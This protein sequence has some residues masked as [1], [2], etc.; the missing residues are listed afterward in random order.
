MK[1]GQ[2]NKLYVLCGDDDYSIGAYKKMLKNAIMPVDDGMNLTEF[3]GKG[4]NVNAIMD[5]ARTIPFLAEKR[6]VIIT[7]SELLSPAGKKGSSEDDEDESQDGAEDSKDKGKKKDKEYG[8]A[9]FFAE[10]PDTT[11]MIFCEEHVDRR[12]KVFKAAAKY[13]YVATFNKISERDDQGIAR[14]QGYVANRLKKDN[15]QMTK[16]AWKLFIER[17]GTDLRVVFTELEKLTCY[18]LEKGVIAAEDVEALVPERIEDKIFLMTEYMTNFQQQQALDLYYDLLRIKEEHPVKIMAMIYRQYHQM[19]VVKKLSSEG[20]NE[21]EI[22]RLAEI[23]EKN[24]FQYSK[25][26]RLSGRYTYNDLKNAMQ[27]CLDYDKA[28]R[29]GKMKDHVAVEM[30]IVAMSSR[31]KS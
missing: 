15:M 12:S 25:L 1:T 19:Y 27:M 17:T 26:L 24:S 18:A 2:F 5:T 16:G 23:K 8:L 22:M 7:D 6:V 31:Q 20:V 14:I 10:I 29:S 28:F 30:V 21:K 11:V 9:E 13:G 3:K 4:Q